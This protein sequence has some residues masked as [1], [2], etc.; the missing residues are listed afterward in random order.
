MSRPL[1]AVVLGYG[2]IGD[3]HV[4]AAHTLDD[5]DVVGVSGHRLDRATADT[6]ATMTQSNAAI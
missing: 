3:M 2:F 6:S 4:R 5:V 1:R